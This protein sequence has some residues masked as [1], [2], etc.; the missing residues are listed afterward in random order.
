[1]GR[2]PEAVV[3]IL[4]NRHTPQIES[5]FFRRNVPDQSFK[6]PVKR[7]GVVQVVFPK[8]GG[9]RVGVGQK[10]QLLGTE[11]EGGIGFAE[12]FSV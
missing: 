1:M 3:E 12:K 9:L 2:F 11:N 7:M 8:K 4:F 10:K 6:T 5:S